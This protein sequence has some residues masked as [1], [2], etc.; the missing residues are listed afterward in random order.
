MT[1]PTKLAELS[2]D[3]ASFSSNLELMAERALQ[4]D[5]T[6]TNPRSLT[7]EQL[8]QLY[9]SIYIGSSVGF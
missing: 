9:Q 5:C 3:Q 8:Q 7:K 6:K 1:I 4:D 2:I